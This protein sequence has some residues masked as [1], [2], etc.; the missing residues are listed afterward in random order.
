MALVTPTQTFISEAL[1]Y[2][3]ALTPG[4]DRMD[5]THPHVRTYPGF[6]APVRANHFEEATARPGELRST[7][8]R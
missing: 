6:F 4:V 7:N 8:R 2:P 3:V 5:D 1:G